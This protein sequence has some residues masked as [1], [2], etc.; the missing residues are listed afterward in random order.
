MRYITDIFQKF[1]IYGFVRFLKLFSL[2][3]YRI[4]WMQGVK[5]SYSQKG[6]DLIIE[7][8]LK[9]VK[10][11]FYVDIGAFD[12]SRFSNTKRF[13]LKGWRGINIEPDPRNFAKFR[14]RRK[15][16]I[17]INIGVGRENSTMTFYMLFPN[18]LSTFS[19]RNA[20]K[21][22]KQGFRIVAKQ[23]IQVCKLSDVLS[24]HARDV[25]D[26]VSID[27]EGKETAVLRSNDWR[28]YRPRVLCIETLQSTNKQK[29]NS[30][31]KYMV[32]KGYKEYFDN[33]LNT[34]FIDRSYK[35]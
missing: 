14:Q 6:E 8:I 3:L 28:K 12:P 21:H 10:N 32:S 5:K 18:S 25:I 11:G 15:K 9:G 29:K 33:G 16:D 13:Y 31:E 17:N 19:E 27:T 20:K 4:F 30:I 22:K 23:K 7:E 2:E 26:F 34:I 1:K 24:K 35:M